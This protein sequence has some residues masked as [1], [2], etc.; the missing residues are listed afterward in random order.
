[1]EKSEKATNK[2]RKKSRSDG[3]KLTLS[4]FEGLISMVVYGICILWVLK[5]TI[6][7]FKVMLYGC[8]GFDCGQ[9][10]SVTNKLIQIILLCSLPFFVILLQS[11]VF[12]K[13]IVLNLKLIKLPNIVENAKFLSW[14]NVSSTFNMFFVSGTL[15]LLFV[16]FIYYLYQ[17]ELLIKLDYLIQALPLFFVFCLF[18]V[19]ALSLVV[20]F[21]IQRGIQEKGMKMSKYDIRK[22][23]EEDYG[24]P[25]I[26]QHIRKVQ[27]E[28]LSGEEQSNIKNAQ[29]RIVNPT[30]IFIAIRLDDT[31][32][33]VPQIVA[34]YSGAKAL[35]ARNYSE[36]EGFSVYENISMARGIFRDFKERPTRLLP[37]KYFVDFHQYWLRSR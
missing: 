13:G 24:K 17:R 23:S 7:R 8:V 11:S 34:C 35:Q 25:L 19:V 37:A 29:V 15:V 16:F 12:N 20:E 26:K 4:M 31:I 2:R 36:R 1:M 9:M 27:N 14:K 3:Q 10:G 33:P 21:V 5:D 32:L 6:P 30:H 28:I 18:Y 22:E